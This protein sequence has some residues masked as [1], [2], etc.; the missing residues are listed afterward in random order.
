VERRWMP[1]SALLRAG[2]ASE[3]ATGTIDLS[4]K[5][6]CHMKILVIEMA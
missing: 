3:L 1:S 2:M 6:F 5:I 4:K